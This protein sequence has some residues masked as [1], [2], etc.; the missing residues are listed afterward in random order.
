M[1][2]R[3]QDK[4]TRAIDAAFEGQDAPSDWTDDVRFQMYG[5]MARRLASGFYEPTQAVTERAKG[6]FAPPVRRRALLTTLTGRLTSTGARLVAGRSVQA[7]FDA[8]GVR[9][10]VMYTR[11]GDHIEIWGDVSEPGWT[12]ACG[13]QVQACGDEGR[14]TFDNL[15]EG[16]SGLALTS[17][18][19]SFIIP[20]LSEL[21]QDSGLD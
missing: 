15:T 4:L 13:D 16:G 10:R 17:G 2:E 21:D 7:L 9:V 1:T 19:G 11:K 20:P 3:P 5:H 8:D 18:N 12:A 6:L 14:F